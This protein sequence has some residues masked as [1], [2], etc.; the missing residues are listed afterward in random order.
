M[1]KLSSQFFIIQINYFFLI[2][3]FFNLIP[4]FNFVIEQFST[5]S[6]HVELRIGFLG[7]WNLDLLSSRR[8][9]ILED[10]IIN[11]Y[12]NKI[13]EKHKLSL[14]SVWLFLDERG[15]WEYYIG[16]VFVVL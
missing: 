8:V 7:F 1:A 5:Q 6:M 10:P 9:F 11:D 3:S 15:C 16:V 2:L 13:K 4:S 14:N 12:Y